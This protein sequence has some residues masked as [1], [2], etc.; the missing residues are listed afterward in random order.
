MTHGRKLCKIN[1]IIVPVYNVESFL[2]KCLDSIM[3]QSFQDFEV[4]IVDDGSTDSS[5]SIAQEYV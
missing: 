1:Y 5:G 4:I 3:Q 2:R